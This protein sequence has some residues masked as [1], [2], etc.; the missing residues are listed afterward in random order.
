MFVIFYGPVTSG[1]ELTAAT[2]VQC[3]VFSVQFAVFSL[4]FAVPIVPVEAPEDSLP[5]ATG[6]PEKPKSAPWSSDIYDNGFCF[7]GM[8]D[9]P[10]RNLNLFTHVGEMCPLHAIREE[11][12]VNARHL[13][14]NKD[15]DEV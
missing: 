5:V 13:F 15:S 14:A 10:F 2:H 3:P 9:N 11:R 1:S 4:Q 6:Q 12:L 7:S 8:G